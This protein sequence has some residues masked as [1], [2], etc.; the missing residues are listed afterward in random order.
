MLEEVC[1]CLEREGFEISYVQ[2]M[3]GVSLSLLLLL[4]Q[5]VEAYLMG[6]SINLRQ[7]F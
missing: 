1:A 3:P 2:A 5:Y 4:V 7:Y 6:S